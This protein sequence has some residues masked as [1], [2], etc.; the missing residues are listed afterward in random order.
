M[1]GTPCNPWNFLVARDFSPGQVTQWHLFNT[2]L[3]RHTRLPLHLLL[4][5]DFMEQQDM[6]QSQEIG[7]VYVNLFDAGSLIRDKGFIGFARPS[8]HNDEIVIATHAQSPVHSIEH[9]KPGCRIAT[10]S[11]GDRLMGL[12]FL[13]SVGLRTGNVNWVQSSSYQQVARMLLNHE[14]D[15]GF[16]LASAFHSFTH[17]TK[18]QLKTLLESQLGSVSH[19]LLLNPDHEEHL[20]LLQTTLLEMGQKPGVQRILDGLGLSGG[21]EGLEPSDAEFM[22]DLMEAWLLFGKAPVPA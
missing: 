15:A 19:I 16:F 1:S 5:N 13:E 11:Y 22:I 18:R 20:P 6:L 12:R 2:T 3:Q 14:V 9:L 21:F 10:T 7:M 8:R 17:M 4:P